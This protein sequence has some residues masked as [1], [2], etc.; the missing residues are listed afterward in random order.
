MVTTTT[1]KSMKILSEIH[2][3]EPLEVN[4]V[5]SGGGNSEA[6]RRVEVRNILSPMTTV[7]PRRAPKLVKGD[8]IMATCISENHTRHVVKFNVQR[9]N[10]N[11]IS[12]ISFG[13]MTEAGEDLTEVGFGLPS[14]GCPV[15]W[16]WAGIKVV[17]PKVQ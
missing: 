2:Y 9:I 14:V 10:K 17:R 5:T 7:Y 6:G 11:S 4:M 8:T 1:D 15:K 13:R 3:K 12:I 16:K